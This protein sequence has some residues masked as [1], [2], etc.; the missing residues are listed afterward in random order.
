MTVSEA[1][2]IPAETD[3]ATDADR[4]LRAAE[5]AIS[6]V[7]RIGVVVSLL[8]VTAGLVMMFVHHGD[9]ASSTQAYH[10]LVTPGAAIPHSLGGVGADLAHLDGRGVVM[11]GLLL[12]II[13]PVVRVA[14][15]IATF[16]IQR[17]LV[18]VL[19]TTAVLAVLVLS[20]FLGR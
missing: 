4:R 10:R 16:A 2:A 20:F 5:T 8:V 17:D 11:A 3:A 13:T 9:Y 7:L 14:V 18:F 12:L 19:V 15:S 6:L 1:V